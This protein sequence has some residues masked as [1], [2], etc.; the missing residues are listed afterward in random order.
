MRT[1]KI[2][3]NI[4]N[5]SDLLLPENS[6]LKQKVLKNLSDIN[7]N[8][9]WYDSVYYDFKTNIVPD[10]GFKVDKIRFSGFYSQGDGAMFEGSVSDFTKFV[11]DT[12]IKRLI[13]NN[14]LDL[15]MEFKHVG[16]YSHERSYNAY[17]DNDI[18][19]YDSHPNIM[20]YLDNLEKEI[21]EKYE[22]TCKDLYRM[23]EKECEYLESDESIMDTIESKCYEF[24]SDGNIV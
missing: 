7:T 11:S 3:Q 20:N 2:E 9:D 13:D 5:H 24:D 8:Y 17:L 1:L 4:Y 18:L 14:N 15:S 6:E 10:L 21:E 16:N 19:E 12:R 23:L 22:S